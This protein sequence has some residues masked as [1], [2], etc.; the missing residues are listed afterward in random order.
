MGSNPCRELTLLGF[1]HPI[2]GSPFQ[3]Q[4]AIGKATLT[5]GRV[6]EESQIVALGIRFC[7]TCIRIVNFNMCLY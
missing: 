2:E 5:K 7:I 6:L 4:G 3:V 1:A